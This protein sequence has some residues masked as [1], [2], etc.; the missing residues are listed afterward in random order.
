MDTLLKGAAL[1]LLTF[2]AGVAAAP[3]AGPFADGAALPRFATH[4]RT[5]VPCTG[6]PFG[7]HVT[8]GQETEAVN[9]IAAGAFNA[10]DE[11]Q[12]TAPGAPSP[13]SRTY[14]APLYPGG[15][16]GTTFLKAVSVDL[17]GDGRDEVV[18]A[19]RV[20]ATGFLRLGVFRR[21]GAGGPE[22]FDTWTINRA[23]SAV[24]LAAGDLDG[25]SD[26]AEELGVVITA[27]GPTS[28]S[29]YVLTGGPDGG[30]AQA[31]GNAAGVW[32]RAVAPGKVSLAVGDMILDGR[33]QLV[34]VYDTGFNA[35]RTFNYSLLGFQRNTD[36]LPVMAGNNMIGSRNFTSLVGFSYETD[37]GSN[38]AIN[39]IEKMLAIGGDVVDTAAAE[40]V[41]L[42]QFTGSSNAHYIGIRL[43]HFITT[44]TAGNEITDIAL[45]ARAPGREYDSSALL[46]GQNQDALR[47]FD[48]AIASI[49]RVSPGE[50]VVARADTSPRLAVQAFKAQ[51]DTGASYL[52]QRTGLSVQFT[53]QS[54]GPI[55]ERRWTFGT[56]GP[57]FATNPT[58]DFPA[59]GTYPVTLRVT[60]NQGVVRQYSS[61]IQVAA[62][63]TAAG[64]VPAVY[65]YQLRT[66]PAYEAFFP[67][68]TN[69]DLRYVAMAIGD[70]NRDGIAEVSTVAR[71]TTDK[72]LRSVWALGNTA[73]PATFAGRHTEE[74]NT[75]FQNLTAMD[76]IVPDFDGDSLLA[77]LGTDCRQVEE[78]QLRQV[79]YHPP[80]FNRLQADVDKLATFGESTS[81]GS[82]IEQRTGTFTS[83][84]VSAYIGVS[85]GSELLGVEASVRATAGYNYQTS[86]GELHGTENTYRL[87]QSY[88][89]DQGEAL[90]VVE[91]NT[92]NCFSYDVESQ[93]GGLNP[94]SGVR[95][96]EVLDGT[97][98]LSATDALFW[99]TQVA[100][101]PANHPPAQWVPLH[102]D[103]ASLTLFRPVTSNY[104]LPAGTTPDRVT[105]GLFSS[106][107]A[108]SGT[109]N[110]FRP[111]LEVDLGSVQDISNIR[112]VPTDGQASSLKGFRVYASTAPMPTAS[113]PGGPGVASFAPETGDDVAY[114]RW[115]IWTR[116]RTA[117]YPMLK[118]RYLRLQH[119]GLAKLRVAQ[120]QAFGDV[121]VE[122]PAYPDDVCDPVKDDGF[123]RAI[124]WDQGNGPAGAF[125]AIEVHGDMVWDGTGGT[126]SCLNWPLMPQSEIWPNTLIG[127]TGSV[128]WNL[129]SESINLSGS[130][131]EFESSVR[132]GAEFDLA[133]GFIA[134]VQAGAAYEYSSGITESVQST[135]FWGTG[136]EL[137][138]EM[139]GFGLQFPGLVATCRYNARPYAFKMTEQSNTG[140]GHTA[141]TVDYVV[142]QG[143]G[144]W[145]RGAVPE[146]CLRDDV[147]FANGFD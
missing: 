132:V 47:T 124:V 64:G 81:G 90:V 121:H 103:W 4:E 18:T 7:R 93:A 86:Y 57:I 104:V 63:G 21:P 5:P 31:D 135:S 140:Y 56:T 27:T 131:T 33:D 59:P 115:S 118:A 99:D 11:Y 78:P 125:R 122:P 29:A 97:R 101:A 77:T 46:Q 134:T 137:G 42:T 3:P 107:A 36:W 120:I 41:V 126:D 123:F 51:V 35:T 34:V 145:L 15:L 61:N 44:R 75:V 8:I 67:V 144:R 129:S 19:N 20:T 23:F 143:P 112:I 76:V 62:T 138:G 43:H 70:M 128:A 105:D 9:L 102:R 109:G 24:D 37:G 98:F 85:A 130:D 38:P 22:L 92:F 91:E 53:D 100:G 1:A 60:D 96:C 54:T 117:P 25:S 139:T 6:T 10:F 55:V 69:S 26:G 16:A 111:Y 12:P 40:L 74:P 82:G 14:R 48:A 17:N 50:V 79:I 119:P 95:M 58:W 49:D 84:D 2:A 146:A 133:V 89:Q 71:N 30:I 66:A 116:S 113:L 127:N 52:W 108:T 65:W 13:L 73:N 80:Y 68:G 106:Q 32:N 45:A 142:R 28:M 94:A 88:A 141:Y 147:V 72:V 110:V 136:L 87:D 83:H 39:D 114:D